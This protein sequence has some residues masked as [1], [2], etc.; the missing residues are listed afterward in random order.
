L[1]KPDNKNL[2]PIVMVRTHSR[3]LSF[4]DVDHEQ[5]S[6]I[7]SDVFRESNVYL[8][9]CSFGKGLKKAARYYL[10]EHVGKAP[11]PSHLDLPGVKELD[12]ECEQIPLEESFFV[13]DLGVVVSQVYQWRRFFPRIEPFYAVKC[14]PDPEIIKTLAILGCNFDCASRNE[15]RLVQ[16]LT[17]DLPH[18]PDILY[19]NP[20]KARAHLIEAVCKGVKLVTFDNADEVRKCAAVSKKIELIL[21]IITDDRGSQCRFSSKFGAPPNKWRPLLADAKRLGLQV[22]GVSF[23]VGSGCRDASKYEL[24]L[25]DARKIFDMAETEFGMKMRILDIGGGFPGETHSIWNPAAELDE[26][27]D[28]K[29]EGKTADS[30]NEENEEDRFMFF[31]EIAERVAPIVD[32]LFPPESGVRIIAEPGRY[33]VAAAATLC[34]SV[35]AARTNAMDASCDPDAINDKEAAEAINS[36]SREEENELIHIRGNSVGD[37][38]GVDDI[39]MLAIQEELSDYSKLYTSQQLSQQEFDVYNDKLDMYEEGYASA[40]D[41]LGPPREDQLETQHHTAEGMAMTLVAA[42]TGPED[43]VQQEGSALLTLAAAGEAAVSGV[44]LQ[45]VAD[46]TAFQDDYAYYIN[47]GVYGAFNNIMFDHA[48]IRPRVLQMNDVKNKIASVQATMEDGFFKLGDSPDDSDEEKQQERALFASTVFG[49]TC[50]SI[51]VISRSALLP[52]LSI[53]DWMYFQNMGAYTMAAA[54]SFNGFTPSEKFYVCSVQP[55]YF[56]GI[57]KGPAEEKKVDE[58]ST[59]EKKSEM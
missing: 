6:G 14:N 24:A 30:D 28:D 59:E 2:H 22:V 50:D 9:G 3:T 29:V 45:A 51:D 54:S 23:H 21:R 5:A 4:H 19:A 49:P 26:E 47:D 36:M 10:S 32:E 37:T 34:C 56:E 16:E 1:Y 46:S 8:G 12:P 55:E 43:A 40:I 58:E 33:F 13:V 48:H 17:R 27:D 39:I 41:L 11:R 15:I 35:V 18:K 52:R 25:R 38:S 44:F 31:T 42:T 57:I 53:G 20:C 7:L